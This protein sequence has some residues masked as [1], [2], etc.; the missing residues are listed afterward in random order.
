LKPG[1]EQ[2]LRDLSTRGDIIKT[3]HR[4]IAHAGR[5]PDVSGFALHGDDPSAPVVGRL[6]ARG[7]HDELKGSA[8]AIVEGIDG[9]THHLRFADLE[10]TGDAKPGAIVEARS[11]EDASGRKRLSLATRSDLAIEAQVT[12]SGATWI[13]RQLLA[14]EPANSGGGFGAEVREAM[15]RRIDHLV[16]EGM[17]RRQGQRVVFARDL[18]DALKRR[19]LGE[20]SAKLA[21]ETGLAHRPSAEGEHVAGVYRQRVALASGRFA[22]IDDGLGFQLVPWRPALE[23]QL[24]REVSGVIAPGGTVEWN[25]GRRRGIGI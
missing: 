15:D 24:G 1:A 18:L 13:D 16:E 12:A 10:L 22:M 14:R 23:R 11:Y 19:E 2:T 25:F 21:A 7:L 17:A 6:V 3:M 4:A 5:D 8:Y 9:R 20:A